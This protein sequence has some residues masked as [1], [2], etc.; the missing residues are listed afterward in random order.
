MD[1]K[2]K[3]YFAKLG[4]R[5]QFLRKKY[6]YNL[7]EIAKNLGVVKQTVSAYEQGVTRVQVDKLYKLSLLYEINLIEFFIDV[8]ERIPEF[9]HHQFEKKHN[10]EMDATESAI[11][12]LHDKLQKQ[13]TEVENIKYQLEEKYGKKSYDI[14]K[15]A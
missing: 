2:S 13:I 1:K 14:K 12:F 11:I 6:G 3:E 9:Q 4:K 5:L 7:S 15:E 10:I 8:E